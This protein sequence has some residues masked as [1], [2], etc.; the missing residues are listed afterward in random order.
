MMSLHTH[1]HPS[2]SS[3]AFPLHIIH[4][5]PAA[6]TF[7]NFYLHMK[8]MNTPNMLDNCNNFQFPFISSSLLVSLLCLSVLFSPLQ[9]NTALPLTSTLNFTSSVFTPAAGSPLPSYLALCLRLCQAAH[10]DTT[11]VSDVA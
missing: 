5:A 4:H 6:V 3:S 10:H 2:C 8:V 9:S 11:L 1:V 7:L